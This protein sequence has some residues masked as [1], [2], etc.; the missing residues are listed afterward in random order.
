[1]NAVIV[2]A[3]AAG[4]SACETL[5]ALDPSIRLT[6]VTDEALPLYSRCLLPLYLAGERSRS[7]LA[8][9]PADWAEALRLEVVCARASGLVPGQRRLALGAGATLG[10]DVLLIAT[11]ARPRTPPVPGLAARGVFTLYGLA[12]AEAIRQHLPRVAR[13]VVLGAGLIGV[14]AAAALADLGQRVVLIEQRATVMPDTLDAHAS[15]LVAGLLSSHGVQVRTSETLAEVLASPAGEVRGARLASGDT[16]D[17]DMVILAVGTCP[18]DQLL[19]EAGA[20]AGQ[21]V[22]VDERLAT[23]LPGVF[24]AGDVA[25]AAGV[26]GGARLAQANWL[27]AKREGRLAAHSMLGQPAAYAGRLRANAV[28]LFGLPLV[29]AGLVADGAGEADTLAPSAGS[30]R[31]LV[32][33]DG[34]LQGLILVGEIAEAGALVALIHTAKN[35]RPVRKRLLTEGAGCLPAL[36]P[37]VLAPRARPGMREVITA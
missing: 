12:Q 26:V 8:F 19:R 18:N 31:K 24:A 7:A 28:R 16:L 14:K 5:R 34:R 1:M 25:E 37:P 11:G 33:R 29:S 22:L 15:G 35:L 2:G 20:A 27:N 21:G 17:C 13:V 3:S 23:S 32:Y 30:Y 9:R 36:G 4:G 10:Y 6:L